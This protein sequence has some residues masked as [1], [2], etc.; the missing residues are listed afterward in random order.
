MRSIGLRIP[1]AVLSGTLLYICGVQAASGDVLG[2]L[3]TTLKGLQG[4]TP[5][6]GV[7]VVTSRSVEDG[8]DPK[9]PA[10]GHLELDFT[11]ADGL[12]VHMRPELLQQIDAEELRNAADPEQKEPTVDLLRSMGPTKIGHM[13]SAA[14]ALLVILDGATE[15]VSKPGTFGGASA[16]EL[17]VR[18]PARLSKKDSGNAKD[19]RESASIWL[20]AQGTPLGF[21]ETV[22]VKF[23]KFFLCITVDRRQDMALRVIGDRLV[24]VSSSEELKQSGLGQGS[25]T[26]TTTTL[27]LQ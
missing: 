2:N 8:D 26:L 1:A 14:R 27:Q 5:V 25:D 6:K 20:D 12:T 15:P 10:V 9:K 11:A 3:N 22:H 17:S 16:T 23:C 7:I 19:Y 18:L 24:A 21:Q 13:V 4:D